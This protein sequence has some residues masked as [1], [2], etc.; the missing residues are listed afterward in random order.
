MKQGCSPRQ[1]LT[2]SRCPSASTP[3][4]RWRV[5]PGTT[6]C[7]TPTALA[8]SKRAWRTE[9]KSGKSRWQWESISIVGSVLLGGPQVDLR[10][11]IQ[12]NIQVEPGRQ[13]RDEV[14]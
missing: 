6:K 14:S 3:G 12:G 1:T 10:R 9:L 13:E 11:A 5:V 4:Q 8:R 7:P 2:S